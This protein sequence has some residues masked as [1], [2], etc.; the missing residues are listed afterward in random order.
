VVSADVKVAAGAPPSL[1]GEGLVAALNRDGFADAAWHVMSIGASGSALHLTGSRRWNTGAQPAQV[2]E[3]F[4]RAAGSGDWDAK[5]FIE[6]QDC[7]KI[8]RS[9]YQ[10]AIGRA[11]ALAHDVAADSHLRLGRLIGATSGATCPDTDISG[12]VIRLGTARLNEQE[13]IDVRLPV[14]LRFETQPMFL[15]EPVATQNRFEDDVIAT[16]RDRMS[17]LGRATA[18]EDSTAAT[19]IVEA[20]F[21]GIRDPRES[22]VRAE[23]ALAKVGAKDVRWTSMLI[24]R[25]N[26]SVEFI[27]TAGPS[28]V[29][30]IEGGR[31]PSLPD[32]D[33]NF[34]LY[35]TRAGDHPDLSRLRRAAL[36]DARKNAERA[37]QGSGE[38]V[39]AIVGL[40][41]EPSP[42]PNGVQI[43]KVSFD[44]SET[45]TFAIVK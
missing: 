39:G 5:F 2:T 6:R 24:S 14:Q 43:K 16:S 44:F 40:S 17:V 10:E 32:S 34:T 21:P 22:I 29:A 9:M 18:E 23:R 31:P 42:Y 11:R 12:G 37:L 27:G 4:R 36:A 13:K 35:G 38:R 1:V 28:L 3:D 8:F 30:A 7:A 45:V 41:E 25:N 15:S 26:V 33:T 20:T 19:M